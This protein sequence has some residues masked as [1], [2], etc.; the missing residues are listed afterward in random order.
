MF[1]KVL[2]SLLILLVL[3]EPMCIP[4][5]AVE[6]E[7]PEAVTQEQQEQ[8]DPPKE[9]ADTTGVLQTMKRYKMARVTVA[10]LFVLGLFMFICNAKL[11]WVPVCEFA[12]LCVLLIIG[13]PLNNLCNSL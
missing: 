9:F 2:F 7:P 8:A 13:F 1:K 11:W 12:L 10:T 4:V 5:F 6:S 3:T